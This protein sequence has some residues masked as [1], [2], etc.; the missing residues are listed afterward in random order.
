MAQ[1]LPG[2]LAIGI[3]IGAYAW[4]DPTCST[5][6]YQRISHMSDSITAILG[7][8]LFF[9]A[10]MLGNFFDAVRNVFEELFDREHKQK[11]D[12]F[13]MGDIAKAEQLHEYFCAYYETDVNFVIAIIVSAM[14]AI[15]IMLP[16][17][18]IIFIVVVVP[19]IVGVL[20]RDAY[21]LHQDIK[22]ILAKLTK[23]E[24]KTDNVGKT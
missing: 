3:S 8:L 10:W 21:I 9:A 14:I 5:W 24:T 20:S 4:N 11:L 15:C 23:E 22:R 2:L 6:S 19:L 1:V 16:A 12:M 13:F 18:R 17:I 7:V